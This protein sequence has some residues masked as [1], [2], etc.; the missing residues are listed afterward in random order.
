MPTG[1]ANVAWLDC[2]DIAA[3]A[4][5]LLLASPEAREPFRGNAYELTGPRLLSFR[6]AVAEI[7][8]AAGRNIR[9]VSLQIEDYTAEEAKQVEERLKELGY[10]G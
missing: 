1:D 6:D 9:F 4:A 7:G 2:R 3:M 5:G 10:L 8:A